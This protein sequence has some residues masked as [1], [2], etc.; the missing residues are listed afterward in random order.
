MGD[1]ETITQVLKIRNGEITS[2]LNCR[3]TH[4][5]PEQ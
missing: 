4:S 1:I 3:W 2:R 5:F